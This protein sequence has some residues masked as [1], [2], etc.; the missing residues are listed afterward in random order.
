MRGDFLLGEWKVCPKLNR[1]VRHG[2][3]YHLPPKEMEVV[4]YL[5][6]RQGDVVSKEELFGAVWPGTF[7]T[8]DALTRCIV[9]LRRIFRDDAHEP[10]IIETIAKR[11][12]R[13]LPSVT[14]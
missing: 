7:V 5:A 3:S 10:H 13:L 4:V 12:Y 14:F 2:R 11:G 8:D 6:K 9:E 1:L